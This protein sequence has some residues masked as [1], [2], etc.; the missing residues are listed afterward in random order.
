MY[1]Y[2]YKLLLFG[3]SESHS[4]V[5]EV[6]D[7]AVLT[8]EG[9]SQNPGRSEASGSE[10]ED[11][12][13][14]L[15]GG[16]VDDHVDVLDGVGLSSNDYVE[17]WDGGSAGNVVSF[18]TSVPGGSSGLSD[19]VSDGLDSSDEG[20][21]GVRDGRVGLGVGVCSQAESVNLELVVG[22]RAEGLVGDDGS[23]VGGVNGSVGE[24][25]SSSSVQLTSVLQ[26]DAEQGLVQESLVESVDEWWDNVVN[27]QGLESESE[28][29]VSGVLQRK[30]ELR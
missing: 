11:G 23:A 8:D 28:D 30:H 12:Q 22:G 25:T 18:F 19:S 10:G 14:A 3:W 26:P 21:S 15:G 16:L 27:S 5:S 7:V 6:V 4:L 17:D 1:N 24:D 20:S 2:I 9:I 29:S 13:K